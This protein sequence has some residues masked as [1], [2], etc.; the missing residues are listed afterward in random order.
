MPVADWLPQTHVQNYRN[1]SRVVIQFFLVVEIPKRHSSLCNKDNFIS[2]LR[3]LHIFLP[4]SSSFY[5]RSGSI[6]RDYVRNKTKSKKFQSLGKSKISR[7]GLTCKVHLKS[8]FFKKLM[9]FTLVIVRPFQE[10]C[11]II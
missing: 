4:T 5:F 3:T 8:S 2:S 1:F 6:A 11:W 7:E 9:R 10:N